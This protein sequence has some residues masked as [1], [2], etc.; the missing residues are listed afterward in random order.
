[1][2]FSAL[3]R[4]LQPFAPGTKALTQ[5]YDRAKT[6][7]L[8]SDIKTAS[9]IAALERARAELE[10]AL[11]ADPHW[12]A[13]HGPSGDVD[14]AGYEQAFVRHP[15]H[16]SWAQLNR[17]IEELRQAQAE[18]QTESAAARHRV[19]L[20]DI[21]EQ[22]RSDP[23]LL[24]HAER[25]AAASDTAR[26]EAGSTVPSGM[27]RASGHAPPEAEEASVSFVIRELAPLAPIAG[28]GRDTPVPDEPASPPESPKAIELEP[29][30]GAEAE[31]V[32]V[33]RRR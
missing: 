3:R 4:V 6:G 32:I 17:A 22:I 2:V 14:W 11:A 10:Q 30:P 13:P 5:D 7:N 21:L 15:V 26:T 19:S 28:N 27:P 33:P 8:V 12:R 31:V 23:L 9:W 18:A 24:R 20:R 29:D 1:M 16:R 25:H